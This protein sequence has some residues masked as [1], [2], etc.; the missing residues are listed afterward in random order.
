MIAR[1][2]VPN[3]L[4]AYDLVQT[5]NRSR[6]V[7]SIFLSKVDPL[8]TDINY[9]IGT[10]W[11]NTL[12][13][14][15]FILANRSNTEALWKPLQDSSINE[16]TINFKDESDLDQAI[17]TID[18]E[19]TFTKGTNITF[20]KESV[21][22]IR[23]S[24]I[25]DKTKLRDPTGQEIEYVGNDKFLQ[26]FSSGLIT[27]TRNSSNSFLFEV[28]L[29]TDILKNIICD[30]GIGTPIANNL[31]LLGKQGLIT[32]AIGN[33][34][35]IGIVDD[36]TLFPLYNELKL[37]LTN[38]PVINNNLLYT[39]YNNTTGVFNPVSWK[40]LHHS[41]TKLLDK[42]NNIVGDDT[43]G[44]VKFL[45]TTKIDNNTLSIDESDRN[46]RDGFGTQLDYVG[47]LAFVIN[48]PNTPIPIDNG[49]T[50]Q[51]TGAFNE[52]LSI[53]PNHN[54][55]HISL[56]VL[57]FF[58]SQK[59][60]SFTEPEEQRFTIKEG[61]NIILT[62]H[63]FG[64]EISS[65]GGGGTGERTWTDEN[66][67]ILQKNL[68]DITQLRGDSIL[69]FRRI[70]FGDGT[71]SI[72]ETYFKENVKLLLIN[73]SNVEFD[74]IPY[75]DLQEL[76]IKETLG[77]SLINSSPN[78]LS[79]NNTGV[80][81]ILDENGTIAFK[82]LNFSVKIESF[83]NSG[84]NVISDLEGLKIN[85][86][87]LIRQT[88]TS[89]R[90]LSGSEKLFLENTPDQIQRIIDSSTVTWDI[91]NINS[92]DYLRVNT[93]GEPPILDKTTLQ[94]KTGI[95]APNE[96]ELSIV[97]RTIN[98]ITNDWVGV[99]NGTLFQLIPSGTVNVDLD[100]IH[101]ENYFIY[102]LTWDNVLGYKLEKIIS[103]SLSILT[104]KV[105]ISFYYIN[106][107]FIEEI[108]INVSENNNIDSTIL[109]MNKIDLY[110]VVSFLTL[111]E[112]NIINFKMKTIHSYLKN[113]PLIEKN[114]V[115]VF[116]TLFNDLDKSFKEI[117]FNDLLINEGEW[118]SSIL[119]YSPNN[120]QTIE[121]FFGDL[122]FNNGSDS[123]ENT[124]F[125]F[126]TNKIIIS[127]LIPVGY[128]LY[129]KF[130]N[131]LERV[132]A[133]SCD[134]KGLPLRQDVIRTDNGVTIWV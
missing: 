49:L 76:K 125:F 91:V 95:I 89:L 72:G 73:S 113:V 71:F 17:T 114:N 107:Q 64:L 123:L 94:V 133:Q 34:I 70:L 81:N 21:S 5:L 60:I 15:F 59:F 65:T 124:L 132:D 82:D 77:I 43:T 115:S 121:M 6:K 67:D 8:I 26:F 4:T 46:I 12:N 103:D 98:I 85:P 134:E 1:S 24:T 102:G 9:S 50:V 35:D 48:N 54:I 75:S 63:Q 69:G 33:T 19:I 55:R 118:I 29:P 92:Q 53:Y 130:D 86:Q 88:G 127:S 44:V 22:N 100:F 2:I 30:E 56:Q 97:N 25:A 119:L 7:T 104:N 40:P 112:P 16:F 106:D 108:N 20:S 111:E 58:S 57:D 13:S 93:I 105:A 52:Q 61:E 10:I 96:L 84:L 32:K 78:E 42:N 109:F 99:I 3:F 68:S 122:G 129:E 126:K 37:H 47:G 31:F 66:G 117:T 14:T 87:A 101:D 45:R 116:L 27:I 74:D 80:V 62:Q 28:N 39:A 38:T 110:N 131:I 128:I 120:D 23:I 18:S 90:D 41:I 83:L 11:L 36:L 79:I 51:I